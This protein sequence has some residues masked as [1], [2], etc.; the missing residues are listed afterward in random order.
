MIFAHKKYPHTQQVGEWETVRQRLLWQAGWFVVVEEGVKI[1]DAL[2][3]YPALIAAGITTYEE[4]NK[5]QDFRTIHG[6][7]GKTAE[8]L[9]AAIQRD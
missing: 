5:I 7:G 6:I 9:Y 1:S 4:L 8:K 2:P 3:G